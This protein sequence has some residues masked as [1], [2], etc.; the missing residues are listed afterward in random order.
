MGLNSRLGMEIARQLEIAAADLRNG[1][2]RRDELARGTAVAGKD[3]ARLLVKACREGSMA[4]VRVLFRGEREWHCVLRA[5]DGRLEI[6]VICGGFFLRRDG[7]SDIA[8]Y[9]RR[10]SEA[11]CG[12]RIR[13]ALMEGRHIDI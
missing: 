11:V 4:V 9:L 8:R 13:K 2:A 5:A 7:H 12:K 3:R 1:T 10:V 6:G